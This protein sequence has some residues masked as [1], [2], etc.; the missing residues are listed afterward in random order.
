MTK[1]LAKIVKE[2]RITRRQV[3]DA[4]RFK[5]YKG[6]HELRRCADTFMK[7]ARIVKAMT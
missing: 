2:W 4:R 7:C 5:D 3:R 6:A 1:A